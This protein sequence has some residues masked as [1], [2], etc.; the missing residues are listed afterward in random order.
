MLQEKSGR[1]IGTKSSIRLEQ[2]KPVCKW[3]REASQEHHR[4]H[5]AEVQQGNLTELQLPF[6]C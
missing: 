5:L 2:R 6:P 3:T 1:I 4:P